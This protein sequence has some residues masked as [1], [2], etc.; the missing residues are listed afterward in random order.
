MDKITSGLDHVT[1][2]LIKPS[3]D[4]NYSQMYVILISSH[5]YRDYVGEEYVLEM[6]DCYED[7]FDHIVNLYNQWQYW[8]DIKSP[9]VPWIE[10][11]QMF[12][13]WKNPV[14]L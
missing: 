12:L 5:I 8:D 7:F 9:Q 10:S 1:N 4:E 3:D 2:N 11:Y 6:F 13:K 14:T